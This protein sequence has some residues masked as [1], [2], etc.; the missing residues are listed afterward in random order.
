MRLAKYLA[1]AGVASRRAAAEIVR[2][3]RVRVDGQIEQ[4]PAREIDAQTVTLDGAPIAG[5]EAP[6]VY[7]LNK[8]AGV[9]STA[10]DSHG[11]PTVV[12]LIAGEQR[13]LYPVGRLDAPSTG[14][15]LLTNDGEL[16][17]L[18]TH[19]RY[20]VPKTY[21]ARVAGGPVSP[22]ALDAL[23]AGIELDDGHTAPA[24]AHLV[25]PDVIEIELREGR[26]RQVRRMCEA[27]GHPVTALERVRFGSL[28][29]G[30]LP[31]G[32]HRLL[33]PAEVEQLRAQARR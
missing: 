32:A 12:G 11:R 27:V 23:R 6:V 25:A 31:A 9:V 7:A 19:P 24:R 15:L 3:G 8:P 16:A 30:R 17:N 22:A 5:P 33:S 29:L 2:S 10:H 28:E 18:L 14:L 1:H 4:D 20:E 26:K 13:R 21:R